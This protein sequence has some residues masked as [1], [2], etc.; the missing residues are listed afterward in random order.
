MEAMTTVEPR[1]ATA[2]RPVLRLPE[3]WLRSLL[4]GIEAA[5]LG[6]LLV[7][8]PAI[9][10]Y[11]ATAA[12][13]LLG[14]ATWVDAVGAGTS[15]WLLGHGGTI[16]MGDAGT[17]S[18]VPLGIS[19]VGAALAYGAARRARIR[20]AGPAAFALAGYVLTVLALSVLVP[21]PAGRPG[22]VLGSL[23]IALVALALALWRG[24][25]R[26]PDWLQWL[27]DRTPSPV[28]S[29]MRAAGLTAG[30]LLAMATVFLGI[31]LV[32]G[33]VTILELHDILGPGRLGAV[34]L[35]LG[36]LAYL[37]TLVVW[38]LAW[39]AGPGFSVGAG[40][41]F[42]PTEVV[43]APLPAVPVLGALPQPGDA[44]T[45]WVILLPVLAG[46]LVG[47]WLHRRR[48]E[49]EWWQAAISGL[50]TAAGTAVVAA[51]LAV[52][53]AG[54]IGP[55][56]M[57]V[58]GAAPPAVAGA[59]AWQV[60][61]GALVTLLL[62]HPQVHDAARRGYRAARAAVGGREAHTASVAGSEDGDV[63][64]PSSGQGASGGSPGSAGS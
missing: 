8:V 42:T 37:P 28:R 26:P 11:V 34:I 52:A 43:T 30:G 9:A 59:L 49:P 7:V 45:P 12:A 40:T 56:R 20:R 33:T 23:V 64:R 18:L 10:A 36:Q 24:R 29:G 54:G 22:L 21:G 17:V 39:L 62:L 47:L 46:A 38:A 50:V 51:L 15:V 57:E 13:P 19:L 32:R 27:V 4:A 2:A 44:S 14:E 58:L 16:D 53:A 25:A 1:V 35:V 31:A 5:I 6:W 55:G 60:G 63:P 48:F 3:T 61:L 41:T